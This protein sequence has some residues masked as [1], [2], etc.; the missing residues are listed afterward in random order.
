MGKVLAILGGI[1]A[2]AALMYLLDPDRGGRRRALARDKAIGLSN[3]LRRAI[4][5]K[6][7]DLSNR[8]QGVIHEA[9]SLIGV[10]QEGQVN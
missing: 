8:A 9:K 1:G 10:K 6:S 7:T 3:D 4:D 5:K 2:G